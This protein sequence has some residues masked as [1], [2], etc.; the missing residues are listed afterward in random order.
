MLELKHSFPTPESFKRLDNTDGP[1]KRTDTVHEDGTWTVIFTQNELQPLTGMSHLQKRI[2]LKKQKTCESGI[3]IKYG[4]P[5]AIFFGEYTKSFISVGRKTFAKKRWTNVIRW[6]GKKVITNKTVN[7]YEPGLNILEPLLCAF[8]MEAALKDID[9]GIGYGYMLPL[10]FKNK[11]VLKGVF[12]GRITN[13]RNAVKAW[14]SSSCKLKFSDIPYKTLEE[15][16][17]F[18]YGKAADIINYVEFTT[19]VTKTLEK[20]TFMKKRKIEINDRRKTLNYGEES[21]TLTIEI[22]KLHE[23]ESLF[24][25]ILSEAVTL[26]AKVNPDW[27]EKR[28]RQEHTRF[29]LEI[30]QAEKGE[31]PTEKIYDLPLYDLPQESFDTEVLPGRHLAGS[32]LNDEVSVFTEASE[33]RH[34]LYNCYFSRIKNGNY[35]ALSILKPERVTVGIALG[36]ASLP[37]GDDYAGA[38]IDQMH[39]FMNGNP[40]EKTEELIRLYFNRNKDN[41]TEMLLNNTQTVSFINVDIPF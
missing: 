31:L 41:F 13:L 2:Y 11:T 20:L 26:G 37:D 35:I 24:N 6:D 4:S 3:I 5:D 23:M 22:R 25:D 1:V 8:G 10:V 36:L 9:K 12:T 33:M 15:Y 27:S 21:E 17:R 32:I 40:S 29:S 7:I 19:S 30:M 39:T 28:M 14:L 16:L 38:Y 18:S 34:C